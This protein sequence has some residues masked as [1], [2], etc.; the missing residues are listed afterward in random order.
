MI[1]TPSK[2]Y[3]LNWFDAAKGVVMAFLTAFITGVYGV[4]NNGHIPFNWID[5]KPIV[6]TATT[7]TLAYIIKQWLSGKR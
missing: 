1:K 4:F 2:R 6:L 3:K 7:A 5:W